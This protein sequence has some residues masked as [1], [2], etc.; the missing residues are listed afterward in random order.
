MPPEE[1]ELSH[2]KIK[3]RYYGT[4]D[5]V[6]AKMLARSTNYQLPTTDDIDNATLFVAGVT[7]PITENDLKFVLICC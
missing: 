6:A 4:N 1:S 5:P 3:D 7:P 2:Q